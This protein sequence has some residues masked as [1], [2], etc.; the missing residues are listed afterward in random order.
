MVLSKLIVFLYCDFHWFIPSWILLS[1]LNLWICTVHQF[2]NILQHYFFKYSF[3]F[4][5]SLWNFNYSYAKA[6][7]IVPQITKTCFVFSDFL[8]LYASYSFYSYL[9]I[10][11]CFLL[12]CIICCWSLSVK[13]L[14][15]TLDFFF[16]CLFVYTEFF[17]GYSLFYLVL[18]LPSNTFGSGWGPSFSV[19]VFSF[20]NYF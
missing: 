7:N 20:N 16:V 6:V 10:C 11:W 15:L 9:H 8:S 12:Q 2:W 17:L 19:W 14:F 18:F 1:L 13:F 4:S 5:S 3:H